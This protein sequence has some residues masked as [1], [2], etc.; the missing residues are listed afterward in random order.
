[1]DVIV[2]EQPDILALQEVSQSVGAPPAEG[3]LLKGLFTCRGQEPVIRKD[4]H[5]LQVA[6][7]LE[8]AGVHCSWFWQP[9]KIGYGKYDEGMALFCLNQEIREAESFYISG[10]TAYENWKTRKVLGI[11][12]DQYDDWFYSVH[13]GWWQDEE[14][15]FR[16]QWNRLEQRLLTRKREA[17]I[18]LLGDFNSPCGI[19]GQG[20]DC[21]CASGWKDTYELAGERD[22]GATVEGVIDGWESQKGGQVPGLGMRIDYIWC[23]VAVP[24]QTS[25][26]I[27]NGSNGLKVSD[28]FGVLV[29]T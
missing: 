27:F 28:H 26:V 8:K 6:S 29:T 14:E 3:R 7:G 21:V 1:M 18:W 16:D 9:V 5:A 13:M 17:R 2:K 12:T 25:R 10:C 15:S 24:V 23:S 22:S 4:N 20:Y 19:A 11:R